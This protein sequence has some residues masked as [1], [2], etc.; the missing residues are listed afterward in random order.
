MRKELET[1]L[2]DLLIPYKNVIP[3]EDIRTQLIII[4]SEYE[5][6]KRKTEVAIRNE[7]KNNLYLAKFL[8]A[9]AASGRTD[10]TLHFYKNSI[11][12]SL[13]KMGKTF[14]EITP[15]DLRLYLAVRI[16]KDQVSKVT[17]NNERRA[18]SSFYQWLQREEILLKNPMSKVDEIK[19][20]KTKKEAFSEMD[21]EKLRHE[22][23]TSREKM[24]LEFLLSTW[25][26]VTE[27]AQIKLTEIDGERVLVHGKG[28]KD[29]FVYLNARAQFALQE[30]LLE[31]KDDNPYLLPKAK[32]A[33]SGIG[34]ASKG[35][36]KAN[37]CEWYKEARL[38]DDYECTDKGTIES[39]VRELG[40]RAGVPKTHPHRFR[41][42][43][44]TFAL[45]NG[46]PILTVSKLLGHNNI[47]T[48]MIYLDISDDE[49][50][51]A[52]K[53]YAR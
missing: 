37:S 30:Y 36:P 50:E 40:K 47:N 9:K 4:L 49:L 32:Y 38:V 46:M 39:I 26:R 19:V 43:G 3:L 14:D 23:R 34:K 51:G 8:A 20:V 25:C 6:D 42:T 21:I 27:L 35:I 31:R 44:A 41:R 7:D 12:A 16:R 11:M 10:R 28:E 13:N 53:K 48:T 15:D 52:H 1:E 24:I 5:I 22:C 18:L 29:R 17:V 33:G 45:K 2:I